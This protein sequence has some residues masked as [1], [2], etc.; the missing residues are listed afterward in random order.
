MIPNKLNILSEYI[1]ENNTCDSDDFY[2]A[3]LDAILRREEEEKQETRIETM[4]HC[5]HLLA[6]KM[7]DP[8]EMRTREEIAELWKTELGNNYDAAV[9][10]INLALE[11]SVLDTEIKIDRATE[12]TR[13]KFKRVQY[14]ERYLFGIDG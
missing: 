13:Y 8:K 9:N 1:L 3:Y 11:L 14:Y 5:L 6:V 4:E 2:E 7:R 10:L 12:K